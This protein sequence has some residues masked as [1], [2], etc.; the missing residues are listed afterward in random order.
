MP[1]FDSIDGFVFEA[2]RAFFSVA[3]IYCSPETLKH[4]LA[5][6]LVS[7]N[8]SITLGRCKHYQGY[9]AD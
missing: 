6:K 1:C 5:V 9:S 3:S 4:V 2:G 8:P 7:L